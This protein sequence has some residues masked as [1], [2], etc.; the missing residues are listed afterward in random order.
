MALIGLALVGFFACSEDKEDLPP[1]EERLSQEELHVLM[2]ADE[3]SGIADDAIAEI[4][5]AHPA[6]KSATDPGTKCYTA[7]YTDNGF[8]A[9]FLDC[10]LDGTPNVSGTVAVTYSQGEGSTTFTASF[11]DFMVGG[12]TLNGTRTFSLSVG[13]DETS[14]SFTVTSDMTA[15]L[16]DGSTVVEAGTKTITIGYDEQDQVLTFGLSGEWTVQADGHT[17]TVETLDTL[18]GDSSCEYLNQGSVLVSKNGL[19]VTV[20]FGNGDC[21]DKVTVTY[22]NGAQEQ[23]TL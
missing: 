16:E 3:I 6:G 23:L 17:Y 2:D 22:P 7:E 9:S 14:G 10:T 8:V 19:E 1:S 15:E 18:W 4:Y 20:D 12:I 21:D 13:S 5:N 11:E